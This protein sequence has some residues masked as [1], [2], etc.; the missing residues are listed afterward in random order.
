MTC[1]ISTLIVFETNSTNSLMSYLVHHI[2]MHT[3]HA[4]AMLNLYITHSYL[5]AQFGAHHTRAVVLQQ[6]QLFYDKALIG[7]SKFV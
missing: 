3:R 7:H 4:G 2:L 6:Q 1:L 5:V